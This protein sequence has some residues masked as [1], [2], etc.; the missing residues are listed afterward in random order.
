MS[1]RQPCVLFL[2]SSYPRNETDTA[3][4]FLSHL[5]R[6][7][8]GEGAR[9]HVLAPDDVDAVH[10]QGDVGAVLHFFRY[11]PRRLQRLAYG[12][13]IL[14]NLARKPWLWFQVPFFVIAMFLMT[15]R[16]CRRVRPD[17]I[18][19]HW[20]IPQG[21][22][23][24]IVGRLL[25][26]PVVT[27]A[28]GSDAFGLGGRV[29]QGVKHWVVRHSAAWT[30]NTPATAKAAMSGNT[31]KKE[32]VIVPMGVDSRRF[33]CTGAGRLKSSVKDGVH[34]ILFVGRLIQQKGV[35]DLL[36]ALPLLPDSLRRKT[37][38][39]IVGDGPERS[40][41]V[42]LAVTIGFADRVRFFGKIDNAALVEYYAAADVFVSPSHREGQGVVY[43]EAL[44]AGVPVVATRV[45]GIPDM[46]TDFETA[47]LVSPHDPE[48]IAQAIAKLAQAADLRLKLVQNGAE[49]VAAVYDWSKIGK[50]FLSLYRQCMR[51]RFTCWLGRAKT[52][53]GGLS[54]NGQDPAMVFPAF[55]S[56]IL[57]AGGGEMCSR[58]AFRQGRQVRSRILRK[59]A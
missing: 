19:A 28:H 2:T 10:W 51:G 4:V 31:P 57:S 30:S 33:Q 36:L 22:V 1:S 5:A 44:A 7:V 58:Q 20:I 56:S 53:S 49:L 16:L 17:I 42:Q 55:R 38:L 41:L 13:G 14:D 35:R 27:T 48:E 23:G 32:A 39:W 15:V 8:H 59:G 6:A 52:V 18:H 50:N 25:R 29:L 21:V 9:V 46:L 43:L 11:F 12:A 34:T 3:S 45:G 40:V 37:Q 54:G 26:I 24:V 47:L